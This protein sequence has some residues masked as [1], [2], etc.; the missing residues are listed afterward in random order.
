MVINKDGDKFVYDHTGIDL[1]KNQQKSTDEPRVSIEVPVK[2]SLFCRDFSNWLCKEKFEDLQLGREED[3]YTLL[4]RI[5]LDAPECLKVSLE[6]VRNEPTVGKFL[7]WYK[8]EYLRCDMDAN[9][10]SEIWKAWVD[11]MHHLIEVH[12]KICKSCIPSENNKVPHL[13]KDILKMHLAYCNERLNFIYKQVRESMR[14]F[15][16]LSR[17]SG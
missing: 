12:S 2:D 6:T 14:R 1:I 16:K 15:I 9:P 13:R 7:T 17:V 10:V 11:E 5:I 4:D 3:C 8:K